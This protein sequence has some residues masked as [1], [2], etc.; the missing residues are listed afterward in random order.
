M[1]EKLS[2]QQP[3][4]VEQVCEML[5]VL[6]N[7]TDPNE[8]HRAGRWLETL[9]KTVFAWEL[10]DQLLQ[11]AVSVEASFYAAQTMRTKIK[12]HF[13][14]L[15]EST[16]ASL[17][18]AL[19]TH[20]RAIRPGMNIIVTQL[21]LAIADLAVY[22]H[23]WPNPLSD[24]MMCLGA[25]EYVQVLLEVLTV[26][27]EEVQ[28]EQLRIP[29]PR[30]MDLRHQLGADSQG[31]FSFLE[32][33]F[34]T[35]TQDEDMLNKILRCL[36]SWLFFGG[37]G[38]QNFVRSPMLPFVFQ[39]MFVAGLCDAAG[40]AATA[41]VYLSADKVF[42]GPLRAT[43]VPLVFSLQQTF[44]QNMHD[45]D[46]SRA[47]AGVF[48]ELAES[49]M[50]DLAR[51]PTPDRLTLMDLMLLV[52][53]HPDPDI[54]QLTFNF[55]YALGEELYESN[56]PDSVLNAFKPYLLMFVEALVNHVKLPGEFDGLVDHRSDTQE[57]RDG[58]R[59]LLK[60][61]AFISKSTHI[62]QRV[63]QQLDDPARPWQITEAVYCLCSF[64]ADNV[65]PADHTAVPKLLKSIL[66]P[67]A[68]LT[69]AVYEAAAHLLG[70][71]ARWLAGNADYVTPVF[72]YLMQ[73]FQVRGAVFAT[74]QSIKNI[75]TECREHMVPHFANLIQIIQ[76]SEQ[77]QLSEED[78]MLI[79]KGT[80]RV[81]SQLKCTDIP[82]ASL[83]LAGPYIDTL[84][85]ITREPHRTVELCIAVDRL[86][87]VFQHTNVVPANMLPDG[88]HPLWQ[89]VEKAFPAISQLLAVH[90]GNRRITE[91]LTRCLKHAVRSLGEHYGPLLAPTVD[92]VLKQFQATKH[93]SF[94]YM[95]SILVDTFGRT[96]A[97]EAGIMDMLRS[98]ST[99]VF[100]I[101]SQ[102]A[103]S[104]QNHPDIVEDYFRLATRVLEHQVVAMVQSDIVI[105]TFQCA[106]AGTLLEHKEANEALCAFLRYFVGCCR[107]CEGTVSYGVVI[108]AISGVLSQ[109]GEQLVHNLI[110]GIAGGLP[111]FMIPDIAS[112]L[113]EVLYVSR[114][115]CVQW[116]RSA[117]RLASLPAY[118]SANDKELFFGAFA[119]KD[120][121]AFREQLRTFARLFH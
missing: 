108:N 9:Q 115:S 121:N 102:D 22:M 1:E 76:A 30:R 78:L 5:H 53:R 106:I 98:F 77:L 63:S 69:P 66:Q 42:Q 82:Q 117:P 3:P 59:D 89:L 103:H 27:P 105:T 32:Q 75:C 49:E 50:L 84:Y 20:L 25:P 64:V 12:H 116:V 34:S 95:A 81:V 79:I 62:V 91:Q 52:A 86:S 2:I 111:T 18:D 43:V 29:V 113:W 44:V 73:G 101:L 83:T 38:A 120:Q 72:N 40:E 54:V 35:H 94:L 39:S 36:T 65:Q 13:Y 74:G 31:V 87:A 109:Y 6:H 114:D 67:S 58:V 7:N 61:I 16:H 28:D 10:S 90:Q 33:L 92:L 88:S 55:W 93:S 37:S 107:R 112:V 57:F 19:L 99:S 23:T 68:P 60:E 17:R 8:K 24:F 45:S 70:K 15:P 56:C 100:H 118:I 41:V 4:S 14:E 47:I 96:A 46:I 80:A 104:F 110:V 21:S 51:S 11:R 97:Y 26:L 48:S 71:L 119:S 85:A